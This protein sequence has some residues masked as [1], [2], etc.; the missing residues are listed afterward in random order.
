VELRPELM[1]PIL[2]EAKVLHLANLAAQ[3][4]GA[5]PDQYED[6]LAEFNRIAGTAFPIAD[7]Q[8]IYGAEEHEDWVRRILYQQFLKPSSDLSRAEIIEIVSRVMLIGANYDFYL[9][10]FLVNCKHSAGSNLIFWPDLVPDLPQDRQ[11]TAE[12]IAE[13]AMQAL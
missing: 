1:P 12:E 2:D 10:L 11:P 5:S 8:G 6:D 4:D 13:L 7:F 9:E 3:L